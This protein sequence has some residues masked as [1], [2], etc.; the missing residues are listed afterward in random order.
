MNI[1]ILSQAAGLGNILASHLGKIG[2][3]AQ[4]VDYGKPLKRQIEDSEVLING[5][6][7]VDRSLVDS[8]PKLK[9]VHQIGTGTDNIDIEYC[10][11]RSIYVAHVPKVNSIAVAEH[12]LFLMTYLA[13]NMKGAVNGVMHRGVL[14][15]LGSELQGKTLLIIGLG[16]IGSEV[17]RRAKSFGMDV[18]GLTRH[19]EEKIAHIPHVP[20]I[21]SGQLNNSEAMS[22]EPASNII[23]ILGTNELM[24]CLPRADYVSLHTDLNSETR[25]MISEKEFGLMKRNAFLINVARAQIV[26]RAALLKAVSEG[27]IAGA[28]FDVFWEEPADPADPLLE[29]ENFVLT[30]HIA[31]WTIESANRAADIIAK[32]IDRIRHGLIPF[33]SIN[34]F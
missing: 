31:G 1:T 13:K 19:P 12:S 4:I 3:A 27:I 5:L 28:A 2:L 29:L 34:S 8:C 23:Q 24:N 26:N 21:S 7:K 10:T 30:P 18:I 16:Y 32:N 14:N 11:S 6:G 22:S 9:L 20:N 17:A 33:T 15:V 25:D